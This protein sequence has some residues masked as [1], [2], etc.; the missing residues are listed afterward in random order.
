[1]STATLHPRPDS[2][3]DM[4][5]VL[6]G[7]RFAVLSGAGISTDS[8]IPDYRGPNS[9]VRTPMTYQQFAG[10]PD[11][12]RTYWARNHVGWRHVHETHPNG[13][14]LAL[15][16]LEQAGLVTG[17]ITQNVDLLH[18]EAGSHNVIDL[19]GRYDR[20]VCLTCGRV[21]S[22]QHLA[23]RLEALNP[24][25]ME[26]QDGSVV[27]IEIAP[28]ADAVIERTE[29]FVVADCEYCGGILKPEIVY[30]GELVPPQRA[31]HAL[32]LVDDSQ[33]LLVVGSSLTVHSG[34]RYVRRAVSDGL[35]VVIVNRGATRGDA[36]AVVKV[37]AGVSET[38]EGLEKALVGKG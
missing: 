3:E 21:I 25:F 5:E 16:R 9:P 18:E 10:D 24:H 31:A 36:L 34:L 13:G 12:R 15:A 37:D 1:M 14:H 33:A 6:R 22:R 29:G 32:A 35:P 2:F 7:R 19:H 28:D 8:G 11:F 27:D 17:V 30:F 26:D 38:L 23:D 4:V 20:V